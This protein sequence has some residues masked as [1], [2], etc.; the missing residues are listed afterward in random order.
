MQTLSVW[1]QVA[2]ITFELA[3]IG[4]TVREV[5]GRSRNLAAFD[6]AQKSKASFANAGVGVGIEVGDLVVPRDHEPTLEERVAL[7]EYAV[8]SY[9]KRWQREVKMAAY[10]AGADAK[11]HAE[12]LHQLS[13]IELDKVKASL[14][15]ALTG[16]GLALVGVAFLV[17][18]LLMQGAGSLLGTV[19][20]SS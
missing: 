9:P 1:L 18:G 8:Q 15:E 6:E 3:G 10:N 2:G 17:L 14:R 11:R 16:G 5:R 20:G 12:D 13:G 19:S 7:L 4:I